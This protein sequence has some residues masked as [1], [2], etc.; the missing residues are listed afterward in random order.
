MAFGSV[1]DDPCEPDHFY[2][3]IFA[4]AG[5]SR[6]HYAVFFYLTHFLSCKPLTE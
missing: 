6:A 3:E 5:V 2:A 4:A 1:R